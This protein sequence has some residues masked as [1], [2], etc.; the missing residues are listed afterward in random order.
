MMWAD[1][2]KMRV[3]T[4]KTKVMVTAVAQ[5]DLKWEPTLMAEETKI[6]TVS[7]YKF[8]GGNVDNDLR[9]RGHVNKVVEKGTN[10]VRILKCMSGKSWGNSLEQQR[11][12]YIQYCRISMEYSSRS[13]APWIS[14][15]NLKRIQRVQND[16]MRSI[17]GLSKTCPQ[18][19]LHLET[20]LEPIKSRFKKLDMLTW[21]RYARLPP[22]DSRHKML[23]RAIPPRLKTRIGWRWKTAK[24]MSRLNYRRAPRGK[25]SPPWIPVNILSLIHI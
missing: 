5:N 23:D 18:D 4:D 22:E 9:F 3:N 16:A 20:G 11:K 7:E 12:L 13:W 1:R 25:P 21:D 14:K 15:S 6:K 10:R 19:F 8:L 2:W 24:L 17:A